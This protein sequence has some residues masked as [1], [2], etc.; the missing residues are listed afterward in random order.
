MYTVLYLLWRSRYGTPGGTSSIV[1]CT[2]KA[3]STRT[4][5]QALVVVSRPSAG[6]IQGPRAA[7]PG[8][9]DP[10]KLDWLLYV[11]KFMDTPSEPHLAFAISSQC[12]HRRENEYS[13][14]NRSFGRAKVPIG[15]VQPRQHLF[16]GRIGHRLLRWVEEDLPL[17]SNQSSYAT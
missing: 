6:H 1:R 5:S 9:L 3:Q 2:G 17:I 7:A 8:H 11:L 16:L 13:A 14:S 4:P 15:R 10:S 12:G